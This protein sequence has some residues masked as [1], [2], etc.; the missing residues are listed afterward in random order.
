M[1][2]VIFLR[3]FD[4][5]LS[6]FHGY[7]QKMMKC[8]EILIRSARKMRKKAEKIRNLCQISFVQF[9]IS[10]VSLI[11]ALAADKIDRIAFDGRLSRFLVRPGLDRVDR[12]GV[13]PLRFE[14]GALGPVCETPFPD[15]VKP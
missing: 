5:I 14:T 13:V 2:L 15:G 12:R 8:H 10:I 11:W 9:I 7:S 3:N 1:N 4:G 6:E